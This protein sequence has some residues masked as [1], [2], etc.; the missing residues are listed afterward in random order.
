VT[1]VWGSLVTGALAYHN[2]VA[3]DEWLGRGQNSLKAIQLSIQSILFVLILSVCGQLVSIL[4]LLL[5]SVVLNCQFY[6]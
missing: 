3:T 6:A 4:S 5:R 2:V 1:A